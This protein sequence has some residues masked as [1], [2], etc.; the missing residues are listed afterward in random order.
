MSSEYIPPNIND[1][2]DKNIDRLHLYQGDILNSCDIGLKSEDDDSTVPDFYMII[3][4]TCDLSFD[5]PQESITRGG[6][7]NLVP[8]RSLSSLTTPNNSII[9]KVINFIPLI[10]VFK[11]STSSKVGNI[12]KDKISRFMFVPPDGIILIEPMVVDFGLTTQIDGHDTTETS[13]L[14]KTKKLQLRSPFRE[15]VA[16]RFAW[17]YMSIGINDSEIRNNNYINNLK[18]GFSQ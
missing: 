17:H 1:F 8:F 9:K 11:T 13:R 18:K 2:F 4:K 7:I 14:L 12:V 10:S 15:K 16:Q 6:I 5:N 3:T